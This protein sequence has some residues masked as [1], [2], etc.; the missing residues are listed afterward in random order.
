MDGLAYVRVSA[1]HEPFTLMVSDTTDAQHAALTANADVYALPSMDSPL[2]G[3]E[4]NRA[5]TFFAAAHL[6]EAWIANGTTGRALFRYVQKYMTLLDNTMAFTRERIFTGARSLNTNFADLPDNLKE[7]LRRAAQRA[8]V[9][10]LNEAQSLRDV[11]HA[12]VQELPNRPLSAYGV[13][14]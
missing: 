9:S 11:L 3:A 14:F 10:S 6:P 12:K 4:A 1:G 5:R 7:V 8:G 2:G 13:N